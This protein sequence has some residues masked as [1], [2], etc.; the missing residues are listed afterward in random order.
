MEKEAREW[1]DNADEYAKIV[2]DILEGKARK[3]KDS[4]GV[5]ARGP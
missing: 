4:M 3:Q 1:D 2:E 5:E